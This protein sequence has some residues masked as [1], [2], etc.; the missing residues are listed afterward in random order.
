MQITQT[1][2]D[3]Y[4]KK[5]GNIHLIEVILEDGS[6]EVEPVTAQAILKHP[7]MDV[8]L[9]ASDSYP[10]SPIRQ[11]IMI[12]ENCWVEGDERIRTIDEAKAGAAIQAASLF[13]IKLAS[14]KKL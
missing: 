13:R 4:K 3:Q 14:I 9:A 11:G 7:S 10:D 2:L 8:V 5:Y 1:K 12:L 6:N